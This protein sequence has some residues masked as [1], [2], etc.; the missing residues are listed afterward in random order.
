MLLV[1]IV[2]HD[3]IEIGIRGHLAGAK[4][5]ERDDRAFAASDAAVAAAEIVLRLCY[6]RRAAARR[7]AAQKARRPAP[8]TPSLTES[9]APIR[10]ICSW[11]N[12]RMASST[13]S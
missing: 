10:N 3:E 5:A 1:E 9:R 7:Q 13:A 11:P 12:S 8:P 6:A 2:D 4:P